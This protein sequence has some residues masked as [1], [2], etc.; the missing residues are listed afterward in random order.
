MM[1]IPIPYR[2]LRGICGVLFFAAAWE[3]F[4]R[5]G[6][7]P[8]GIFPNLETIALSLLL[9]LRNGSI[10]VHIAFT[11]ARVLIGLTIASA[12]SVPIGVLMGRS[13]IVERFFK[14]PL[15]VLMPVP[16]LAWVPVFILWF[17]VG[18]KTTI[19][20]VAYAAAFPM[21]YNV[22]LGVRSI[23]P[24]WIRSAV[25]MSANTAT[26]FWR[27]VIPASLPFVLTGLRQSFGRAWIA[28]I[29]A[30]LLAGTDYGLGR[31]IF[32]AKEWLSTD[33]MLA[34]IGVIGLVG[35]VTEKLVFEKF[36]QRTVVRWGMARSA[37]TAD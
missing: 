31:L 36:D 3:A 6:I 16:S 34:A 5:S 12:I 28:V 30:E 18:N 2:A 15:S 37:D 23:K 32:E 9:M 19:F 33:V 20:V 29:G 13:W 24:L 27:V 4:S 21:I 14:G 22:W 10:L 35:L 17:G 7:F 8:Q 25:G 11:L 1:H 26:V